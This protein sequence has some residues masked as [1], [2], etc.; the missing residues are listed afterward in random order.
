MPRVNGLSRRSIWNSEFA[1]GQWSSQDNAALIPDDYD[2]VA[3]QA[4]GFI[5]G[6]YYG[7]GMMAAGSGTV[8]FIWPVSYTHLTL[9]TIL[10][11]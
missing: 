8:G 7:M 2:D 9:P 3:A 4:R 1:D 5:S 10:R 6:D 11:V